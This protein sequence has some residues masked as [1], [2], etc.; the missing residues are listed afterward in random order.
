MR[1]LAFLTMVAAFLVTGLQAQVAPS[2]LA[3]G[4]KF[5]HYEKNK[6][7]LDFFAAE[8]KKNPTDAET[9]F[10]LGQAMLAQNYNGISTPASITETKALY[11]QALQAKGNDAWLLVGMA[12]IQYL[13]GADVNLIRNNLE[14]AIT[15]S[16]I[17]SGKNR[18]KNNPE[19]INAIGR[20]FAELPMNKG[21]HRYAVQ[22]LND[23]I[24]EYGDQPINPSL[25]MYLGINHLKVGGDTAGGYAVTAFKKAAERDPRNPFPYYKIGKIYQSQS[26][27]ESFEENYQ[28]AIAIDPAMAPVYVSLYNYY[29]TLD[30]AKARK[31]LDLF[32]QNADKD[33][34]FDY[35]YADYL[36]QVGQ[37][38]ASLS[39]ALELKNSI[40]IEAYPRVAVLLAYNYDRKG[41]SAS[42]RTYIEQ[43]IN[44]QPADIIQ[45]LDYDLAVKVISKFAGAQSTVASILERALAADPNNKKNALR[46]Y[47]LG[48]EMFEKSNMYSDASKWFERYATLNGVKDEFYYFKT[49]SFALNAK[50]GLAADVAAK[51]Y[52]AAFPDKPR[53]YVFNINAASLLDTGVVKN[54]YLEALN[55]NSQYLL[56]DVDNNKQKLINNF[57]Q[58]LIYYNE[59]KAF[60]KA[61]EMC[62]EILKLAP[63]DANMLKYREQFQKNADLQKGIKKVADKP[64]TEKPAAPP[65]TTPATD[66]PATKTAP[67]KPVKKN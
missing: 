19:I 58:M 32:I 4:I 63:G 54:L 59:L 34:S 9:I 30:T 62:D 45:S 55:L 17:T 11:Q 27:K 39:K 22:K 61:V 24:S 3:Q 23:L 35:L 20:V 18:S 29:A 1:K 60:D 44:T 66:K 16:K 49:A 5:L 13:E 67:V 48:Y 10:W 47:K 2:P 15:S 31:N 8:Y 7:A 52:I 38:D 42:A 50:D 57:S 28:K 41:D 6:S 64:T 37:Y 53:G 26:N 21:N 40:G 12:H 43:F 56:K 51:A 25:Y 46:F 36:F 14:L 33:P 65:P